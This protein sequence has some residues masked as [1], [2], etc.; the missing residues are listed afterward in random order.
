[1][2]RLA[3][4]FLGDIGGKSRRVDDGGHSAVVSLRSTR[5]TGHAQETV[6]D[7]TRQKESIRVCNSVEPVGGVV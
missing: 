6:M 1:M 4:R 3:N 7:A 5:L 2:Q